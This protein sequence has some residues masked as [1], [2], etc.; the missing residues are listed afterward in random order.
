[1]AK[2]YIAE[3]AIALEYLHKNSIVHRDLKPDSKYHMIK[4]IILFIDININIIFSI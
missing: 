1:M 3:T 2:I 4:I